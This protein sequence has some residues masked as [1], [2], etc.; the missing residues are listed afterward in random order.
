MFY[1]VKVFDSRGQLKK[2]VSSKWQPTIVLWGKFCK[3][4]WLEFKGENTGW[5]SKCSGVFM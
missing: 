5:K 4:W 2:V 3:V 1:E